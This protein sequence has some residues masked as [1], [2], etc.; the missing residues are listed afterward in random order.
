[1][2]T[3]QT[4]NPLGDLWKIVLAWGVLNV[5]LGV[6]V[7]AWPGM[8]IL[9]AAVLFGAFLVISG[10]AQVA[11]AF[12]RDVSAGS[13]VLLFIS[14]ALS[15]VLG[16]LAF[17]HF[18]QGYAVLLL[19]I[20]IGVG[21]VFQGVAEAVVAISHPLLP[22]R[23]WHIFLGILTVIAGVVVMSWPF[24]SVVVLAIVAGAW[25]V[26]IGITQIIWAFQAR[27]DAR[28][29]EHGIERLTSPA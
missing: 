26:V 20:W 10:I 28:T 15:V 13:R 22:A 21:F 4:R 24:D 14:G 2:T 19:A 17:R 6:A 11:A 7:L 29:V 5:I 25:L 23:G 12:A 27:K 16:V 9:A 8:S 3:T 18:G 1:M